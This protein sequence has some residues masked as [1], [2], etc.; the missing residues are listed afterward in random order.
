MFDPNKKTFQT[1]NIN[2][3]GLTNVEVLETYENEI[4]MRGFEKNQWNLYYVKIE[5]EKEKFQLS[6]IKAIFIAKS[7]IGLDFP[8]FWPIKTIF[9]Q[10]SI[11]KLR[12]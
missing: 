10:T 6:D 5:F 8:I 3:Q 2:F 1:Q 4:F 11:N 12:L 7:M 9:N